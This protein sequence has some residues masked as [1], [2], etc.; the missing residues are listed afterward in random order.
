MHRPQVQV[1]PLQG[2]GA[3]LGN[4]W[5]LIGLSDYNFECSIVRSNTKAPVYLPPRDEEVCLQ[6]PLT[7]ILNKEKLE[8]KGR[9][10][11]FVVQT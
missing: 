4:S 3:S 5:D 1:S 7:R 6:S 9:C 2:R 10:I 11:D 8:R